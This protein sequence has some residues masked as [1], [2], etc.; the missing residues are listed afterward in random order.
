VSSG[1]SDDEDGF[2]LRFWFGLALVL[3]GYFI[4]KEPTAGWVIIRVPVGL[5]LIFG[6]VSTCVG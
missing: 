1:T 3:V 6:G 4:C 5:L 2:D